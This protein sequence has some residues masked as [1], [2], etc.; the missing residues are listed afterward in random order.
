MTD[1]AKAMKAQFKVAMT[2]TPIENRLA[3]LWCITDLVHD[4][5]LGSLK[6]F[7]QRYENGTSE[8]ISSLK[9]QLEI[10]TPKVARIMLRRTKRD[11]LPDLPQLAEEPLPILMPPSQQAAYDAARASAR[12]SQEPGRALQALQSLQRISLHPDL[13]MEG[14]DQAFIQASARLI[15][16]MQV[17]DRAHRAERHWFSSTPAKCKRASVRCY[18]GAIGC[19]R[20]RC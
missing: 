14:D 13:N 6:E 7:R 8:A 15:G 11:H 19:R 1:A 12:A 20:R 4:A 18:S 17:L 16:L 10:D 9:V 3:E 5:C 2:G